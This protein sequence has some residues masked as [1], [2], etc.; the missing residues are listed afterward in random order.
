MDSSEKNRTKMPIEKCL[1]GNNIVDLNDC[2]LLS[3]ILGSGTKNNNVFKI[4]QN[5]IKHFGGLHGLRSS[6]LRE[7]SAIKGIGI[8]KA[9]KIHAALEIGRRA[10][11]NK[12][13]STQLSSPE[14]VWK[15]LYPETAGLDQE[16]F[17][18]LVLNNKNIL[19]KKNKVFIGTISSTIIHPREIFRM[20]IREGGSGII[21]CHNHP[22]GSLEPSREDLDAT[23]RLIKAGKIIGIPLLDH[24]IIT[25]YGY[26]SLKEKG[27][28]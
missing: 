27:Y 14:A 24:V 26:L 12:E 3:I 9:V 28:I 6:G 18:A 22:S 23:N 17:Y 19:L 5:I 20:A 7:I 11:V 10:I 21:V 2:E 25:D 16:E 13:F 4:S 15:F 1:N 8:K